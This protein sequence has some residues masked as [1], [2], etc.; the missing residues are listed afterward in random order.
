[1][2]VG[3]RL[4]ELVLGKTFRL[5]EV[6]CGQVCS[7]QA[8]S[9]QV[10]SGQVRIGQVRCEQDHVGQVCFDQRCTRQVHS[11]Q[12]YAALPFLLKFNIGV[13]TVAD[14][15]IMPITSLRNFLFVYLSERRCGGGFV[16]VVG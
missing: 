2:G 13:A 10:C 12:Y 8:C 11:G 4:I 16:R 1:M 14:C 3:A 15:L 6:S 7:G 5:G 9:G